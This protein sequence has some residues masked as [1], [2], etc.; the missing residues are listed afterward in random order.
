VYG[1][2]TIEYNENDGRVYLPASF[3]VDRDVFSAAF[4]SNLVILA[5]L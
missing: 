5:G 2:S 1:G 4:V 3:F